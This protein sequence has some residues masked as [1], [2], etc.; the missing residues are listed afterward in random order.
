MVSVPCA[1]HCISDRRYGQ[2][3]VVPNHLDWATLLI[4]TPLLIL[5]SS[6]RPLWS[7]SKLS[8]VSDAVAGHGC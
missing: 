7:P 2:G 3:A 1:A 5:N 8:L 4:A 6:S